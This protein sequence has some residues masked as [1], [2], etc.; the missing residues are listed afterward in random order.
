MSLPSVFVIELPLK[1]EWFVCC[2]YYVEG[3]TDPL[4][5]DWFY[6]YDL[7]VQLVPVIKTYVFIASAY[8]QVDSKLM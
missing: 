8:V 7:G 3:T 1:V 4:W 2:R 6:C 5:E